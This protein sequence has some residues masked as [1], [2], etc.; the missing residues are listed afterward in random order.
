VP[1]PGTHTPATSS[2]I[3]T[4]FA[5]N[6][7]ASLASELRVTIPSFGNALST[8]FGWARIDPLPVIGDECL[9]SFDEAGNPWVVAWLKASKPAPADTGAIAY[10]TA[11]Q[12]IPSAVF[13]KVAVDTVLPDPGS[14]FDLANGWYVCPNDGFYAVFGE[15]AASIFTKETAVIGAVYVN[16]V[17]RIRDNRFNTPLGGAEYAV[18]VSAIV[19]CKAGDRI[20]LW[21]FQNSGASVALYV[22]SG[23]LFN[24][25]Q[26][27]QID[28]AGLQGPEGRAG[29]V[30]GQPALVSALPS[31]PADG[32]EV[33]FQSAAMATPGVVWHLRYRAASASAY[34]WEF[35]GGAALYA[36]SSAHSKAVTAGKWEAISGPSITAP[37]AGD[38]EVR[39]S[40]SIEGS[41][42]SNPIV[43][44]GVSIAGA[45]PIEESRA[46]ANRSAVATALASLS[47]DYRAVGIAAAQVLDQ[48][49]WSN[50]AETV[51]IYEARLLMVPVRVG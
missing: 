21:A 51:A 9:V 3:V 6:A 31:L 34:K 45:E 32:E 26:V 18:P 33:Y 25:L 23:T 7:P 35:I 12:S 50:V 8:V 48:R 38:Y 27:A 46:A 40:V 22:G 5:A 14:H 44:A 42:T 24:T 16:G 28:A 10:R 43:V 30:G 36:Y 11:A 37:L 2:Q 39:H 47:A 19:Y 1:I 49:Y 4:A 29:K 13:T 15:W 17:E 41:S 20:E